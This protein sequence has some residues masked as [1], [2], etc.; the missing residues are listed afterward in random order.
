MKLTVCN[1]IYENWKLADVFRSAKS[2]GYEAVEISP[3]TIADHARDISKAQRDKIKRDA[4]RTGIEIAGLHWLFI[5]PEGLHLTSPNAALRDTTREYLK[6]LIHL[7]ADIGGSMMVIGSPKQRNIIEGVTFEQGF[8]WAAAAFKEC[9]EL[10]GEKDVM[11]CFEPLNSRITN[12]IRNPDE[13]LTLIEAVDHPNFQMILDVY[14]S[15]VESLDIPAELRKHR[16][17]IRHV[18]TNDDNGYVPG[19]GGADYVAIFEA[20]KEIGYERYLSVEV[21]NFEPDPETIARQSITFLRSL[22]DS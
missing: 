18:H 2:I 9:A 17:A 1:E 11:L 4:E 12:F 13:A 21:F 19:S 6:D 8:E 7:C 22:M 20:L 5:K 16:N 14:S 10:A 3:F 15:S